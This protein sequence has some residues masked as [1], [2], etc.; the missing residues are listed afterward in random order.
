[1]AA[2]YGRLLVYGVDCGD[3]HSRIPGIYSFKRISDIKRTGSGRVRSALILGAS[4]GTPM[5]GNR[6]ELLHRIVALFVFPV[7]RHR[8]LK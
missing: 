6:T 2:R 3:G 7:E 8:H 1:M 5:A 4:V